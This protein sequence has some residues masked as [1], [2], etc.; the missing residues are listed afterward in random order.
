MK[1]TLLYEVTLDLVNNTLLSHETYKVGER[2]RDIQYYS[3]LDLYFLL[4]EES[5]SIAVLTQKEDF[6]LY[7]PINISE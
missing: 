7:K 3:P 6:N 4:L 1:A 2:I 5:P